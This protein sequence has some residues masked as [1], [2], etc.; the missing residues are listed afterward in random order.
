MKRNFVIGS[1]GTLI[2]FGIIA[3]LFVIRAATTDAARGR[4]A[5]TTP[6]S[7]VATQTPGVS[8]S[9]ETQLAQQLFN[10][11]NSDRAAQGLPAYTWD[12]KIAPI[13]RQHSI[14]MGQGCGLSHQ[15]SG[16]PDP[17]QRLSNVGI[18]WTACGENA[19]YT[20]P[21]PGAWSAVK[22]N[23][24]QGMLNERPPNDGHRRNLLSTSFHRV[25]IG[26][27]IDSKGIIWV[28]EDF[29]N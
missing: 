20:S 21:T 25:G 7:V 24:E 19:G 1:I 4:S 27:Y 29:T 26:I 2:L 18:E 17:C 28:T 6:T 5:T 15:C 3:V 9:S 23:I 22:T 11:I 12:D 14:T 10:Q 8:G 13:S 16:E